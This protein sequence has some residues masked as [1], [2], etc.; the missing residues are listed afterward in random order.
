[1]E[2]ETL[3]DI[4]LETDQ[5]IIIF[6]D[7]HGQFPDFIKVV[8]KEGPPSDKL[9]YVNLEKVLFNYVIDCL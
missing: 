8:E 5:K 2:E 4:H 9:K 7:I 6:G 1:M 3:H